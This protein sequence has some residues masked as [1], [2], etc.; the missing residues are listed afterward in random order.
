MIL[1][2]IPA[3]C[4]SVS[5]QSLPSSVTWR[6]HPSRWSVSVICRGR[7]DCHYLTLSALIHK[8]TS[9][10][11]G[12]PLIW[13]LTVLTRPFFRV[14][15]SISLIWS[16]VHTFYM[17]HQSS[18]KA[19]QLCFKMHP[20]SNQFLPLHSYN[21]GPTRQHLSWPPFSH[22][23]ACV[24][25]FPHKAPDFLKH[26]SD[27]VTPCSNPPITSW[28]IQ[29]KSLF[30]YLAISSMSSPTTSPSLTALWKQWLPCSSSNML[31]AFPSQD[32]GT[33]C[34][35]WLQSSW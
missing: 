17:P 10:L 19:C 20:G 8:K 13:I 21:S 7:V 31:H 15:F 11:A 30:T 34:S 18:S 14:R 22:V 1:T 16:M 3:V 6:L 9:A 28:L 26:K 33:W 2:F 25:C 27:C 35:T 23:C 4:Q 32:L 24:V 29:S 12:P 5:P